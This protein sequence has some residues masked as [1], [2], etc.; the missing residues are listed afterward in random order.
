MSIGKPVLFYELECQQMVMYWHAAIPF[1]D[2]KLKLQT[3]D[4]MMQSMLAFC[5]NVNL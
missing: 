1:L 4:W 3:T 2:L 5:N